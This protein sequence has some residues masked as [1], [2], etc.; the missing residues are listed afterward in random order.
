M[1][2]M[3]ES[4]LFTAAISASDLPGALAFAERVF[5]VL[6]KDHQAFADLFGD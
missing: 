5:D 3:A 4:Q 2:V 6:R 1:N